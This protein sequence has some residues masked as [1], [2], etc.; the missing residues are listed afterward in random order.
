MYVHLQ[1]IINWSK[2][3]II[4]KLNSYDLDKLSTKRMSQMQPQCPLYY[5]L[6]APHIIIFA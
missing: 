3:K 2:L 6:F 5:T 1:V 4:I